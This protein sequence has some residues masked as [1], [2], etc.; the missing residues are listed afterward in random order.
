MKLLVV[1]VTFIDM[2]EGAATRL[3]HNT[4]GLKIFIPGEI[5]LNPP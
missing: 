1:S 2:D 3:R 5:P 4:L